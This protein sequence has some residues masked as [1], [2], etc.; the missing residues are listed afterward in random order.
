MAGIILTA[1]GLGFLGLGA[2]P[3]QPGMGRD[4][5]RRPR[6]HHRPVVGRDLARPR[7]LR[8]RLGFNLLGDG[9]RDVLDPKARPNDRRCSR[10]KTCASP[11]RSATGIVEAV[12]GVSFTL[13]RER[14][15]IVGES[16]SGK[17]MTGRAILGLMPPPGER[18]RRPPRLRR[19][20]PAAPPRAATLARRCAAGASR[21]VMQDP[22]FSLNPVMTVGEQIAEA[23]RAHIARR[24][25]ARGARARRSP[26]SRRCRSAIPARVYDALPARG[27]RRHGPARDDRHDADRRARPPDR[28]RADLGARRH[29]AAR[30]ARASSTTWSPSAAWA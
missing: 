15:G 11:S 30:G 2:Q 7:H 3:P 14:L 29:R 16:G 21:M 27:L 1:A 22:K 12:R 26:C 17:S 19:H 28:R 9:L 8:R 4:D 18:H 13:G 6:V 20:R 5:R 24:R 10:S 23:Y 25:R